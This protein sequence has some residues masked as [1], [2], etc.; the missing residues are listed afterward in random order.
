MFSLL[1]DKDLEIFIKQISKIRLRIKIH[2]KKFDKFNK[3]N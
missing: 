1:R 2:V 3:Y